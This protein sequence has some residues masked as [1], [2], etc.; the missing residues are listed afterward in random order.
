[1]A[2]RRLRYYE[3]KAVNA[4]HDQKWTSHLCDC[5]PDIPVPLREILPF[6]IEDS[7]LLKIATRRWMIWSSVESRSHWEIGRF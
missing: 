1:M 4:T 6:E 5:A 3:D 7:I 2:E